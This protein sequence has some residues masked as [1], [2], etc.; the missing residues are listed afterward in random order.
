MTLLSQ[1]IEKV[2]TGHIIEDLKQKEIILQLDE[3]L[4]SILHPQ[5]HWFRKVPLKGIYLYGDVGAGKTWLMDF[6]AAQFP[7]TSVTRMHFHAFMEWVFGKLRHFQGQP[8]PLKKTSKILSRNTKVLFLD[9]FMVHDVTHALILVEL[10][11]NL[12]EERIVLFLTSN[13]A[14]DNLYLNGINRNRFLKAIALIKNHCTVLHLDKTIDHRLGKQ[15]SF[16]AWYPE[17][18]ADLDIILKKQFQLLSGIA[19]GNGVISVLNR[20]IPYMMKGARAIWFRFED[21]CQLPRAQPDYLVLASS[22][23]TMFLTNIPK[24]N[25]KNSTE[26]LLFMQLIDILYDRRIRIVMSTEVPIDELFKEAEHSASFERTSSRLH[27]MISDVYWRSDI[28]G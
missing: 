14:P 15:A 4:M 28:I 1:Y 23:Y 12:I 6:C 3:W 25:E 16:A 20:P 13:I 27:E 9:E 19:E 2:N 24:F 7:R 5:H 11:E 17:N 8:N 10:L 26:L 18:T 22:F 21:L